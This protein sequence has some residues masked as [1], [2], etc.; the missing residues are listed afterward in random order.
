MFFS[1]LTY[2]VIINVL[3]R[4]NLCFRGH[5]AWTKIIFKDIMCW[6]RLEFKLS[7]MILKAIKLFWIRITRLKGHS[8]KN[9]KLYRIISQAEMQSW[10]SN[11]WQIFTDAL[12]FW[13]L[14]D[15]LKIKF[16]HIL[17]TNLQKRLEKILFKHR[18]EA[19]FLRK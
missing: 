5:F 11:R 13:K 14:C 16:V 10:S 1:I 19:T 3:N 7:P 2:H 4:A 8:E 17:W 9:V 12:T 6:Y 18:S 15:I